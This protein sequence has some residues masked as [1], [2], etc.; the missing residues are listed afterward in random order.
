MSMLMRRSLLRAV[1]R[2][3]RGFAAAAGEGSYAEKQAALKA[4]A[5][6]TANLWRRISF[7]V[8]APGILVTALW[9][10]KVETEHAA[11]EAHVRAE[12]DGHLP[13]VPAYP[14]LNHRAVPFP[15]GMNSLFFNP[16]VQK[17]LTKEEE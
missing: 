14:Y 10:N 13:E 12:N 6:E 15:W 2:N 5:A 17:D 16:H 9:V 4:H 1:P 8:C 11:H 3:T 7:Y